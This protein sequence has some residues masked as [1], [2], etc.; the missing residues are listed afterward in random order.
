MVGEY[1]ISILPVNPHGRD[2]GQTIR[3]HD[4]SK[5]YVDGYARC[6]ED[7]HGDRVKVNQVK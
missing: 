5:D 2:D 1:L 7:I 4:V 6:L 3:L